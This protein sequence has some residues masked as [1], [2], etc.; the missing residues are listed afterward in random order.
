MKILT[1]FLL[2]TLTATAQTI[3]IADNTANRPTGAN[4]YSTVQL[5][6]DAAAPGDIVFVQPSSINYGDLVINRP[7]T[8]RG[9][10]FNTGR[11]I[12]TESILNNITLT[13]RV[14][15][16]SN[17]SG[18]T[19]E[20]IRANDVNLGTLTGSFTY[21]L[22]N[23]RV[24]NCAVVRLFRASGYQPLQNLIVSNSIVNGMI[25]GV[26]NITTLLVYGCYLQ[27]AST[28]QELAGIVFAAG[29][30]QDATITNNIFGQAIITVAFRLTTVTNLQILNNNFLGGNNVSGSRLIPVNN[31][32]GQMGVELYGTL[33]RDN[34]FYGCAP[35]SSSVGGFAFNTFRNNIT[36]GTS[37]DVLPPAGIGGS[38][39]GLPSENFVGQDPRF[40]NAP[41][42]T[43][44]SAN[45]DFNLQPFSPGKN[46]GTSG[47]IGVTGGA[48][49][50]TS[51]NVRLQPSSAVPIILRFDPLVSVPQNQPVKANIK[52]KSN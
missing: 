1:L 39:L 18:T 47:D 27:G 5:A 52:A 49:P 13:N 16:T 44:Y 29:L 48:F 2:T 6:H 37:N 35:T 8:L 9:I 7:I 11:D 40:I 28:G 46:N 50:I 31:L 12:P 15:G 10:G 19:L 32:F 26:A 20:G 45:M 51:G 14:D 25:F 30:L 21:T 41:Y 22:Q 4:V 34:I 3:R 17:A 42:N 38:N 43:A 23:I 24:N 36:F 33:I